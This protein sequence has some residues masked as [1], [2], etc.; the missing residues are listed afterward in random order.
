MKKTP[1]TSIQTTES[2][3]TAKAPDLVQT[4]VLVDRSGS[5]AGVWEAAKK[6]LAELEKS[7]DCSLF[8][9]QYFNDT[10]DLAKDFDGNLDQAS[11][12]ISGGTN[13]YGALLK[14][15]EH[16]RAASALTPEYK[17]HHVFVIITDGQS[18]EHS[19]EEYEQAMAEIKKMDIDATFFMLDSSPRQ[20]AGAKL[21]WVSTAFKNTPASIREAIEKVKLTVDK[22]S[23]NVAKKI[24]PTSN[25]CLPPAKGIH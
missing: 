18:N 9:I 10:W 17:P 14:S 6:A 19:P 2:T 13:L 8:S 24:S 23:D 1:D 15:I 21:G 25:L 16:S 3:E 12:N 22:I 20:L 11:F 5:M 4:T 7:V